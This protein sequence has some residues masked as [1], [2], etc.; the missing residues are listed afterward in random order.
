[1][2]VKSLPP[3]TYLGRSTPAPK[4]PHKAILDRVPNPYDNGPYVV[5]FSVPE[6]TVLCAVTGQP[7]F[8]HIMIDYVPKDW[9]IES[10]ALKFFLAS[11]RNHSGFHEETTIAIGSRLAAV[12]EPVYL[13]VG[14]YWYPRGG[15]PI[16]VFWSTG[17]LPKNIWL[18]DQGL[19]S[20]ADGG[21][22]KARSS[23]LNQSSA[24]SVLCLSMEEWWQSALLLL[25][26]LESKI[27]E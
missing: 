20:F 24:R 13:R 10:K 17:K 2:S 16:D 18:P 19:A 12:L 14:G 4:A 21:D 11:F 25:S 9:L 23:I 22:A 7:D 26:D 1:M 15:I 6:F 5:R 8:A 27:A 3:L